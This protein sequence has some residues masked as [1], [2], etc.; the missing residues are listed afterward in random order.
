MSKNNRV[1]DGVASLI[2]RAHQ[3]FLEWNQRRFELT[4][5]VGLIVPS[6][7]VTMETEVPQYLGRHALSKGQQITFHSSRTRMK[8]VTAD[9][10][11]N[12]AT[13][14]ERCA[15]EIADANV[16]VVAHACLVATMFMGT[17]AHRELEGSLSQ[18]IADEGRSVPSITSA[19]ALV[20]TL[21]RME[22]SK[23]ALVAPYKPELTSMVEDYLNAESLHV[24]RSISLSE[25]DNRK[26][27]QLDQS[28][29]VEHVAALG[30][31]S[32]D[33]VIASACVQMP[34]LRALQVLASEFRV[35][36]VSASLCTAIEIASH[37]NL[38]TEHQG[39]GELAK[40][41]VLGASA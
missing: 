32:V 5:R 3:G 25:P 6:S 29:L 7:N 21:K 19:G 23:I 40:D 38:V 28:K 1:L 36:V 33:A 35:P 24:V 12:M 14:S 15:R 22:A 16:D 18:V 10:L 8:K 17:G 26:V 20:R 11:R 9:E 4:L 27:A 37:L 2:A 13:D 39:L 41:L 34:S 31:D 30:A